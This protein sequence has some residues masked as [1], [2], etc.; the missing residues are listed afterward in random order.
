MKT[1][2]HADRTEKLAGIRA[3][4]IHK[5]IDGFFD[6]DGFEDFLRSEKFSGYD[7]YDHRKFRHCVEALDDAYIAFEGSYNFV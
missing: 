5:W 2:E 4:D 1:S 6:F 3:E 7:P